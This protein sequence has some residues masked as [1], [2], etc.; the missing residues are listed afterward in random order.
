MGAA[1]AWDRIGSVGKP[2]LLCSARIVDDQDRELPDGA[3]GDLQFSGPGVT[4]GYWRNEEA[5]RAAFTEDGW[6]RS[7]DLARRDA[8]GLF[9]IAGRRKEMFIS[10]GENVYPA[11]VENVLAAHPGV[12]DAAVLAETDPKWG[13]V[14][15]AFVQ[16][17]Q[18]GSRPA[19][20]ELQDFCRARLAPYKVPRRFD[21]VAE[22]P[23]TSAGKI[24]KHLLAQGL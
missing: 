9:W 22:F 8:D 5:T 17:A 14:G 2:Q 21:F 19:P 16:L 4:P 3:V 11:E 15:R 6:L 10:G 18:G 23:R 20:G 24:Q 13:E 1:D 7:G 12:V